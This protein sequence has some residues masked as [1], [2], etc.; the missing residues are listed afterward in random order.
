M[1]IVAAAI[2]Q[3]EL[4][5]TLPKPARHTDIIKTAITAIA[6]LAQVHEF[7]FLTSLGTFVDR[8]EAGRIAGLN[9]KLFSEDLW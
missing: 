6:S 1:T 5:Y 8:H 9:R 3:G 4:V 7:G 2:R